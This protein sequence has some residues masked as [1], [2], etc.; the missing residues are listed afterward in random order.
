MKKLLL[1]LLSVLLLSS[2]GNSVNVKINTKEDLKNL[3]LGAVIGTVSVI[4]IQ[5]K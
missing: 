4:L 2:C 3:K 1:V 5:L